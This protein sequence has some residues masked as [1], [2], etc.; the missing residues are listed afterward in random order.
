MIKVDTRNCKGRDA[1][2]PRAFLTT[3]NKYVS[4]YIIAHSD[5]SKYTVLEVVFIILDGNLVK[6]DYPVQ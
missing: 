6:D 3:G 4:T 1:H 2:N 5:T